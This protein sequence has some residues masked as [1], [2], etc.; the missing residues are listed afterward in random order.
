MAKKLPKAKISTDMCA[1]A[2]RQTK[3][4][5]ARQRRYAAEDAIRTLTRADEI[6]GDK[7]L[8]SDVQA[9]AKEQMKTAQKFA[10]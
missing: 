5:I 1:P 6:K 3:E 8:M 10:K 4:D 2:Y 7:R 9:L